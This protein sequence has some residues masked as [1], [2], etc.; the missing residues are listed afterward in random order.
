VNVEH[1][2]SHIRQMQADVGHL[3]RALEAKVRAVNSGD[4][5][6]AFLFVW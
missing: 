2:V 1:D 5:R 3:W 6:V 4:L